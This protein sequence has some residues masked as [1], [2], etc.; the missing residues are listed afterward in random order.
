MLPE[1]QHSPS[2]STGVC[3]SLQMAGIKSVRAS[4][5]PDFRAVSLSPFLLVRCRSLPRT[6]PEVFTGIIPPCSTRSLRHCGAS[7]SVGFRS[8]KYPCPAS[9]VFHGERDETRQR[10][11]PEAEEKAPVI[12]GRRAPFERL[13]PELVNEENGPA[14]AR[15]H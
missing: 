8:V 3:P 15:H 4:P 5:P 14:Q 1:T 11:P 2:Y 12:R 6:R 9:A 13:G 7:A 10:R